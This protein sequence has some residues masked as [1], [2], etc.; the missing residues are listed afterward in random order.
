MFSNSNIA[1]NRELCVA[2]GT[3]ADRCIMDNLRL[4]VAPCRQACPLE[5]NCQNY[6]RYLAKGRPED[7]AVVL[8]KN[9][10]F[11]AVLGRVCHHPCESKCQRNDVANDG[12]VH[13]RAVK[14]YLSDTFPAIVNGPVP[15]D[16]ATGFTVA[17]VGAGPA[18]LAAAYEL[19]ERGHAVDLYEARPLAGGMLR[20]AIPAYRLP[21][22]IV[23]VAVRQATAR[24]VKL[25]AGKKLGRDIRVEDLATT[26]DAVILALGLPES[27][28]PPVP[29]HDGPRVAGALGVLADLRA[30][31]RPGVASA[32]VVGGGNTAIDT[33]LSLR[34]GGVAEVTVGTLEGPN[35]LPMHDEELSEAREEGIRFM[36]HWGVGSIEDKGRTATVHLERCLALFDKAGRFAPEMDPCCTN[37]LD[38]ELVVFAIGQKAEREYANLRRADAAGPRPHDGAFTLF[39]AGIPRHELHARG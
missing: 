7:A 18:G 21:E 16:P 3:C 11:A 2:C 28:V 8:R 1:V 26:H 29:G 20:Y 36:H 9:T 39:S 23:D 24:G 6:L 37:T 10:P 35:E 31:K 30:G 27:A 34:K 17:V 25:F 5:T 33:A 32:L 15:S 22:R 12:A 19:A 13:I 4:S 38:A 14:R